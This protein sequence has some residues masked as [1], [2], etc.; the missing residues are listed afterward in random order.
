MFTAHLEAE[1]AIEWLKAKGK[2]SAIIL[3]V[4][5]V[6][7]LREIGEKNKQVWVLYIG[8]M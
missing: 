6:E 1:I 7:Y 5:L 8:Q 3:L 2:L 4:E